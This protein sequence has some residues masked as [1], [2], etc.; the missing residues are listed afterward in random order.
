MKVN[1]SSSE[2]IARRNDMPTADGS[3]TGH[4]DGATAWRMLLKRRRGRLGCRFGHFR[5]PYG[6]ADQWVRLPVPAEGFLLVFY[7]NHSPK[8]NRF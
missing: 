8:I 6:H 3:S 1:F 4:V 7:D 2:G 5:R